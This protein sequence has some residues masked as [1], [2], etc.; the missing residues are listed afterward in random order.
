[1]N[2]YGTAHRKLR[3]KWAREIEAGYGYCS[4]IV[5]LMPSRW[6][7]PG[8]EWHLAHNEDGITYRGPAHA[9]CNQSEGGRRGNAHWKRA[10]RARQVTKWRPTTNW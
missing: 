8:T 3:D 5:C 4:E 2:P 10:K 9:F 1:M 7:P 6:I